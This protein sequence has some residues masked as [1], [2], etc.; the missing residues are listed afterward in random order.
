MNATVAENLLTLEELFTLPEDG[1][2]RE[3]IRGALRERPMTRRNRWHAVRSIVD[4]ECTLLT[5]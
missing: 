4:R 2:E 5:N 1:A 3:L